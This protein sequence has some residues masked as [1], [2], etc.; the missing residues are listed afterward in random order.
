MPHTGYS[1]R[2][3]A[4]SLSFHFFCGW[5]RYL[6]VE[7]KNLASF[8]WPAPGGR[9]LPFLQ[10]LLIVFA[11]LAPMEGSPQSCVHFCENFLPIR[12][13]TLLLTCFFD[14]FH[15]SIFAKSL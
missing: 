1:I 11:F 15:Q 5:A 10:K 6:P 12:F 3:V 14:E 13:S 4:L 7:Q 8:S 2:G 9:G